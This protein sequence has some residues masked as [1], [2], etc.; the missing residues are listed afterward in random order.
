MQGEGV[1]V[2]DGAVGDEELQADPLP[3]KAAAGTAPV[4]TQDAARHLAAMLTGRLMA[5]RDQV[6]IA[7]GTAPRPA[8]CAAA[9]D[10]GAVEHE[11]A[12]GGEVVD[13]VSAAGQLGAAAA[14]AGGGG[15][16][17]GAASRGHVAGPCKK[18]GSGVCDAGLE[19]CMR[20]WWGAGGRGCV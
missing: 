20:V 3:R 18:W 8:D 10:A 9:V 7:G 13:A 6:V 19:L 11:A 1:L 17:G 14:P 2:A 5:G 16:A 12:G 4:P 15:A